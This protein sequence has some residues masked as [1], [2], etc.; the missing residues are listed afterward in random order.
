[1]ESTAA[2]EKKKS[3][4]LESHPITQQG[5]CVIFFPFSF[6]FFSQDVL[7]SVSALWEIVV[8]WRG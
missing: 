6:L 8:R 4:A 7:L 3:N 5:K 2:L 1:M